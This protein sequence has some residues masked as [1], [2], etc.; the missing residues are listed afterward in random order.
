MNNDNTHLLY[1]C[2]S[3]AAMNQPSVIRSDLKDIDITSEFNLIKQKKSKLSRA[4]REQV[5]RE[6][7]SLKKV[8][9]HE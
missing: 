9:T 5:I 3:I 8:I 2:A 7:N 6:Y 4:R 1:A